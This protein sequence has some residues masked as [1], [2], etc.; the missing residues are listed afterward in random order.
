MVEHRTVAPDAAGSIPV[1]HPISYSESGH[2]T[3]FVVCS[4]KLTAG[5]WE[6]AAGRFFHPRARFLAGAA[7]AGFS[8]FSMSAFAAF[9]F[10]TLTR[11]RL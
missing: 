4:W 1:I 11:S 6:L 10:S 7:F 2:K 3:A 8:G 5:S 9:F